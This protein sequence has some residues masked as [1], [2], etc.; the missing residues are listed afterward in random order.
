MVEGFPPFDS[1][2]TE[3]TD[4]RTRYVVARTQSRQAPWTLVA[5]LLC[6]LAV[7]LRRTSRISPPSTQVPMPPAGLGGVLKPIGAGA[8][9]PGG[10]QRPA[11]RLLDAENNTGMAATLQGTPG[12][13]GRI[14]PARLLFFRLGRQ[15]AR[16]AASGASAKTSHNGGGK[17]DCLLPLL[18]LI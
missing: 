1:R 5:R 13:R 4:V 17:L 12:Y 16:S 6:R 15:R 18:C 10:V 8:C 14:S 9:V 3:G 11:R 7:T 2:P